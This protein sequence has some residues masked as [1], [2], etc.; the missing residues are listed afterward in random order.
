MNVAGAM[1]LADNPE[2]VAVLKK[3]ILA[4]DAERSARARSSPTIATVW[5][6]MPGSAGGADGRS[7]PYS[8]GMRDRLTPA[9]LSDMDAD[10]RKR[11]DEIRPPEDLH[12]PRTR[13]SAGPPSP[14]VRG[15]QRHRR[16]GVLRQVQEQ[17]LALGRPQHAAN[18]EDDRQRRPPRRH[19]RPDGEPVDDLRRDDPIDGARRAAG[20][21]R[22]PR[23]RRPRRPRG[24]RQPA[25]GVRCRAARSA[26]ASSGRSGA[27]RSATRSSIS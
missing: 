27:P 16:D 7:S 1:M 2:Q 5:D 4:N 3:Q 26:S 8:I 19:A 22:V 18:R 15:E 11:V 13:R 24:D 9:V 17:R 12:A 10:E 23:R 20:D 21:V 25:G 14:A 6:L